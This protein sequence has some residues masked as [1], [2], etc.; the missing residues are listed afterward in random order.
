MQFFT[1][2]TLLALA[3][4]TAAQIPDPSTLPPCVLN[5]T[6]T[7]AGSTDCGSIANV[8]C[9][10]SSTSF[11]QAAGAC[12]TGC[13]AEEQKTALT[14]QT[15]VCAAFGGG[16]NSTTPGSASNSAPNTASNTGAGGS[17]SSA[18][19]SPAPTGAAVALTANVAAVIVAA[20]ALAFAL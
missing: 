17:P 3:A 1:V 13:T 14:Y 7:S 20:A 9:L 8:T 11:Q 19:D 18:G 10:C 2:T 4:F 5:C 12:L 15:Q 16:G 6:T